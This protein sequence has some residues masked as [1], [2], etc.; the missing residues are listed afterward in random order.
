[1]AA[2]SIKRISFSSGDQRRFN[3][4]LTKLG[5]YNPPFVADSGKKMSKILAVKDLHSLETMGLALNQQFAQAILDGNNS[6]AN[7]ICTSPYFRP[8]DYHTCPILFPGIHTAILKIFGL[9]GLKDKKVA[10]VASNY[11]PYL[12]L[13]EKEYGANV[14]GVDSNNIAVKY[15]R[16]Q[17]LNIILGDASKM[18]FFSDNSFDIAIS[19]NFLQYVYINVLSINSLCFGTDLF[20]ENTISEIHRI[21]RPGGYYFSQKEDIKDYDS[22]NRFSSFSIMDVPVYGSVDILQ[23]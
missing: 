9:K 2:N 16:K 6:L 11:G 23:K 18:G 13:L 17:G 19:Y 14:S 20:I 12:H 7:K 8:D 10:Q 4:S 22:A 21:L 15:A 3:Y 5:R 1:M